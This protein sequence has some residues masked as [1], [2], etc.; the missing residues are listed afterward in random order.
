[1]YWLIFCLNVGSFRVKKKPILRH[2][3]LSG[4]FSLRVWSF[5]RSNVAESKGL[6]EFS[7]GFEQ[8]LLDG[9]ELSCGTYGNKN[10]NFLRNPLTAFQNHPHDFCIEVEFNKIGGEWSIY[11]NIQTHINPF[12]INKNTIQM[13]EVLI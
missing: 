11:L 7:L 13:I 6:G 3:F 4:L 12:Q 1:M 9:K 5:S 2:S 8:E 10:F